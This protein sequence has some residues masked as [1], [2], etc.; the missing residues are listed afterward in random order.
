MKIEINLDKKY[1]FIFTLIGLVVIG[2]IGV[3]AFNSPLSATASPAAFGHSVDELDWSQIIPATVKAQGFCIGTNCITTWPAGGLW[4]PGTGGAIYYNDGNV[5]IGTS[6]P[7]YPLSV[8]GN[9]YVSGGVGI[10]GVNPGS[11]GLRVNGGIA[12]TSG[13]PLSVESGANSVPGLANWNNLIIGGGGSGKDAVSIVFGDT[14][15]RK[16]RI[17][18]TGNGI[19]FIPLVTITDQGKLVLRDINYPN[20]SQQASVKL[21]AAVG[22]GSAVTGQQACTA[23]GGTGSA[24]V[25][26]SAWYINSL[27][28]VVNAGCAVSPLSEGANGLIRALCT[29]FGEYNA[30]L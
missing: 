13:G 27:G 9:A 12:I 30:E 24:A 25:C 16:L 15:G 26:L 18:T 6:T 11:S 19:S 29:D 5:G 14:T 20:P 7:A 28:G 3:V 21:F 8:G 10:G 22:S 2:I 23:K 17:G 1:F 4:T